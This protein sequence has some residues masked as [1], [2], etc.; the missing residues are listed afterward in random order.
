MAGEPADA[1][2]QKEISPNGGF[3]QVRF[4]EMQCYLVLLMFPSP[5]S[6]FLAGDRHLSGTTNQMFWTGVC[7]KMVQTTGG[8]QRLSAL[9][10]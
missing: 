3:V 5:P 1:F 7:C 6:P 2:Y 4:E 9:I 10:Y 8:N